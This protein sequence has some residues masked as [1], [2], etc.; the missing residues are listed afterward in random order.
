MECKYELDWPNN[1]KFSRFR[2]DKLAANH[3]SVYDK[4]MLSIKDNITKD[5]VIPYFII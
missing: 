3:I 4:V 5:Q 1:W 2:D